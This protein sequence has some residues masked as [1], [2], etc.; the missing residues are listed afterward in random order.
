[1]KKEAIYYFDGSF[2]RNAVT[3]VYIEAF[4]DGAEGRRWWSLS[5]NS[6]LKPLNYHGTGYEKLLKI[7]P[8]IIHERDITPTTKQFIYYLRDVK[9]YA[10]G[11]C[12]LYGE[13]EKDE[14]GYRAR[15]QVTLLDKIPMF[16]KSPYF[17]VHEHFRLSPSGLLKYPGSR[18]DTFRIESISFSNLENPNYDDQ[19]GKG[20][21]MY[22]S[23]SGKINVYESEMIFIHP[24]NI[25]D[26]F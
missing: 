19:V 24:K 11:I 4:I 12:T 26:L 23:E 14:N 1:M 20:R 7:A 18:D 15:L 10:S 3:P 8:P 17:E 16:E 5:G 25:V 21:P 9:A 13:D 2:N 6:Y 22:S